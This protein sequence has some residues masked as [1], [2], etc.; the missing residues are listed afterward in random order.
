M[1]YK[2]DNSPIAAIPPVALENAFDRQRSELPEDAEV[3]DR[4]FRYIETTR[5]L[6]AEIKAAVCEFYHMD[7]SLLEGR[8][9]VQETVL[10]RQV[11]YFLCYRYTRFS[12]LQIGRFIG[13]D[14]ATVL[15][16]LRKIEGLLLT[17]QLLA[18]DIDLLR[19]RISEKMLL[20][21]ASQ[22]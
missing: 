17:H 13:R 11:F 22:C 19:L 14:H 12:S 15:H 3:L 10:A 21:K 16:G 4:L 6:M 7:A 18:D 9:R 2:R 8:Q 20:R 5:P 1:D